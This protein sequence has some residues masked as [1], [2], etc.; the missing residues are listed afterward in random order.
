V[1]EKPK[2]NGGHAVA[3]DDIVSP[4][5]FTAKRL[6]TLSFAFV[7]CGNITIEDDNSKSF[8]RQYLL[9]VFL[10]RVYLFV[11]EESRSYLYPHSAECFQMREIP[12]L[13]NPGANQRRDDAASLDAVM[14]SCCHSCQIKD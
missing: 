8:G 14:N 4:L 5:I 3:Q 12:L 6:Q 13:G 2:L 10:E 9:D 11:A 7:P 1:D